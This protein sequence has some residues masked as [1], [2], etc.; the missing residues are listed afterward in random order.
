MLFSNMGYY[1]HKQRRI[2]LR[3][4]YIFA[5]EMVTNEECKGG[6]KGE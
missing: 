2:I 3:F 4:S 5:S 6:C 1:G